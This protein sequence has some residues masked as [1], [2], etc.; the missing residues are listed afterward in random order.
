ME[1]VTV[2][3]FQ[4]NL[5]KYLDTLESGELVEVRGVVLTVYTPEV[6][7]PGRIYALDELK[8]KVQDIE[9]AKS[10]SLPTPSQ[11]RPYIRTDGKVCALCRKDVVA[12]YEVWEDGEE[13][14]VCELCL[15]DRHGKMWKQFA[16]SKI[17]EKAV[18]STL[19]IPELRPQSSSPNFTAPIWKIPKK[20]K[21]HGS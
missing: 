14:I 4:K 6:K 19:K 16:S 3:E 20:S 9:Q 11:D 15:K 8:Q 12:L 5:K 2:R 1:K 10:E 17:E 18:E 21:K 13:R 7:T